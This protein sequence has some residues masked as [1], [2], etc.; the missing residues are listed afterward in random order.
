MTTHQLFFYF[1]LRIPAW[2]YLMLKAMYHYYRVKAGRGD[3]L[4]QAVLKSWTYC[5]YAKDA[6]GNR[7]M[8]FIS[9]RFE[10]NPRVAAFCLPWTAVQLQESNSPAWVMLVDLHAATACTRHFVLQFRC[11]SLP[12]SWRRCDNCRK[13]IFNFRCRILQKVLAPAT[14]LWT[15]LACKVAL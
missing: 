3:P 4:L 11:L 14:F 12:C 6:Q 8:L 7:L 1:L 10:T 5:R 13:K 15:E 2:G 9:I